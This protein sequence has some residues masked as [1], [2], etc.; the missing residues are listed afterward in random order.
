MYE[1]CPKFLWLMWLLFAM[2]EIDSAFA[3]LLANRLTDL[4]RIDRAWRLADYC[5]GSNEALERHYCDQVRMLL[6]WS[7][8]GELHWSK[9]TGS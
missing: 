7:D 1:T 4:N 9:E 2:S 5:N 8:I 3:F 6:P